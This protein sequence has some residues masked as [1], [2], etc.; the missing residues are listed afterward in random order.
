MGVAATS[1]TPL[2]DIFEVGIALG[3]FNHVLKRRRVERGS[4]QICMDHH[5]GCIDDPA[6]VRL[7]LPFYFSLETGIEV[8]EGEQLVPHIGKFFPVEEFLAQPSQGLPD[9]L[10]HY[11]SG[12]GS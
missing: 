11:A 8:L 9:S 5:T 6:K 4:S 10:D 3:H 7:H 2:D 1:L 12:I